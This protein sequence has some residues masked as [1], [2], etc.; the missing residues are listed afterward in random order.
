MPLGANDPQKYAAE[1]D[2]WARRRGYSS[3]EQVTAGLDAVRSIWAREVEVSLRAILGAMLDHAGDAAVGFAGLRQARRTLNNADASALDVLE[4]ALAA[5]ASLAPFL[6]DGS[7]PPAV[8]QAAK[9]LSATLGVRPGEARRL[10]PHP[11]K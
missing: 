4:V 3:D 10:G 5:L 8:A 6:E 9:D 1:L 2:E 7:A 11:R